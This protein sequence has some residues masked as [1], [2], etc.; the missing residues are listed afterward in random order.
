MVMPNRAQSL[1]TS[2]EEL[3]CLITGISEIDSSGFSKKD[4]FYNEDFKNL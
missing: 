3:A 4:V 2:E 1:A